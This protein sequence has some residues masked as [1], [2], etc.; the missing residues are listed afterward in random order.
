MLHNPHDALFR[1]TLTHP[2]A[3]RAQLLTVLPPELAAL[4][5]PE[6]PTVL[7][8]SFIDDA[9]RGTQADVVLQ[10]RLLGGQVVLV[11]LLLEHQ[12]QPDP[13]MAWRLLG[14][15]HRLWSRWREEHPD[16]PL[17]LVFPVVVYHGARPWGADPRLSA[18]VQS[19]TPGTPYHPAPVE[20]IYHL[21]DLGELPEEAL[22]GRAL[23][24]LMKLLLKF[25]G[26]PEG[27]APHLPR[28]LHTWQAA[29]REGG[30][31]AMA[32]VLCYIKEMS[33]PDARAPVQ[34]FIEQ[35]SPAHKE[36]YM[37]WA[38]WD[39]QRGLEEGLERGLER[40]LEQGLERGLE[41]GQSQGRR[42]L[43]RTLL[44]ARFGALGEAHTARIATAT[45]AELLRWVEQVFTAPS[46]EA[47]LA[48]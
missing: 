3:A 36:E 25:A 24:G 8:T 20:L 39:H 18:L 35:A 32:R 29:E 13:W 46:V 23:L 4:L 11:Y 22:T 27:V 6:P 12:S 19:P 7:D 30:L 10:A 9:L 43:M 17:P 42:E 14:Y 26:R 41:Q 5:A 21:E 40:G 15:L 48:P 31:A 34:Q 1:A 38:E 16:E 37:T 33:R 45:D 47:L 44:T 28:W 2:A